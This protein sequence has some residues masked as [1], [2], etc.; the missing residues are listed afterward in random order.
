[1]NQIFRK[2][3]VNEVREFYENDLVKVIIGIR[4]CGKSVILSSIMEEIRKKSDNIIYLN[5][6]FAENLMKISN[7]KELIDYV[8]ANRG[9]EKCYLFLDEIQEAENWQTAIKDLQLKNCSIFVTGSNSKL[10]NILPL[11]LVKFHFLR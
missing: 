4:R 8:A 11:R 2:K 5:F 9:N 1:M 3:Y 6:E 7:A 10:I